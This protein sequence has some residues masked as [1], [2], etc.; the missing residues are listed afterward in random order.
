M[1]QS[2]PYNTLV[3]LL[4]NLA[5]IVIPLFAHRFSDLGSLYIGPNP[6]VSP[7]AG[8]L[9]PKAIQMHYSAFPFSPTLGK[10]GLSIP[11]S[12]ITPRQNSSA[13]VKQE[14]HI[15]P[16]ISW[17]FFGSNRGELVHP[18]EIN[19]G[20]WSSTK[21]YLESCVKREVQGVIR[22][23]EGKS[24]PHKLHLDPDEIIS[25]RHHHMKAVPGDESDESDEWDLEESEEEWEGPGD[26][27]Y[28]DYR[29]MQRTTFL[30]AHM[31]EREECVKREMARWLSLMNR[32]LK[33][34]A[35]KG[36]CKNDG[37]FLEEF[38]LDCHDLSLE[39]VFVDETDPSKIVSSFCHLS[40]RVFSS[41][42]NRPV[43]S[44]GSRRLQGHYGR[45]LTFRRSFN[46]AHS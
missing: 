17:P 31:Q 41:N 2:L 12:P 18:H 1:Y 10:P 9:T 46:P 14:Y 22:E 11:V 16:I 30:V 20:P 3:K 25:S 33:H 29:R 24:A 19:R 13:S 4:T 38:G 34:E 44:I 40:L 27:M 37:M 35:E 45:V 23:N 28:R 36:R 42:D 5:E 6:H 26:I 8:A 43:L 39:N 21:S 32:L 7:I 15:G